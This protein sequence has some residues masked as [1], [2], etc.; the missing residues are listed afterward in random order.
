MVSS[1]AE[2]PAAGTFDSSKKTGILRLQP[3]SVGAMAGRQRTFD[4]VPTT[5]AMPTG[6]I[7]PMTS[8]AAKKAYQK[9]QRGPRM[10]A[11]E[12][13]RAEAAELAAQKKEFERDKNA[14]KAKAAREKKA[15]KAQAERETRRKMGLPEPSKFVR[16]SQPTI[17]RFVRSGSKRNWEEL[18]DITED[19]DGT[20][21][22]SPKP[23]PGNDDSDDEFGQFPSLS[24]SSILEELDSSLVSM[25]EEK[26]ALHWERSLL[27]DWCS[28]K[29][30]ILTRPDL[31]APMYEADGLYVI[32]D[33]NDQDLER[34]HACLMAKDQG[35]CWQ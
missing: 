24:Q 1:L 35:L 18:D 21:Q 12:R 16:A 28:C 19:S 25:K 6:P 13:R 30:T 5:L 14:A 32:L 23:V 29:S 20:V 11:A 34:E 17:S 26:L 33:H 15:A 7:A 3:R 4:L 9:A 22:S 2:D 10:S 31:P 8:K 27:V